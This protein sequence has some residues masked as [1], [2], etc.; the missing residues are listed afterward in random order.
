M[1]DAVLGAVDRKR[2]KKSL[3]SRSS[4]TKRRGLGELSLCFGAESLWLQ[5]LGEPWSN[6]KAK[7]KSE[8]IQLANYERVKNWLLCHFLFPC[9]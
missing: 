8:S 5:L 3:F 1:P 4:Q 2:N 6:P 7:S 9:M